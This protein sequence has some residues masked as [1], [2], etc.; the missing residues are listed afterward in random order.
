MKS[1]HVL[2]AFEH[3]LCTICTLNYFIS[4]EAFMKVGERNMYH[5]QHGK[6]ANVRSSYKILLPWVR[7]KHPWEVQISAFAKKKLCSLRVSNWISERQTLNLIRII[8]NVD[9]YRATT[10]GFG[11]INE[12]LKK[13]MNILIG[14]KVPW[15][16]LS[17]VNILFIE[18]FKSL[19]NFLHNQQ[20]IYIT[21]N[22]NSWNHVWIKIC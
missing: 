22:P 13:N 7:G 2:H 8:H 12:A 15:P 5:L 18:S 10:L 19:F 4:I 14:S 1:R 11:S 21:L 6:K 20:Y 9:R 3:S 17:V 16:I